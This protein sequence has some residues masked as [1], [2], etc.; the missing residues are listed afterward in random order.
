[1]ES[2]MNAPA[3]VPSEAVLREMCE[4]VLS[5]LETRRMP[6]STL[7]LNS[8]K[9]ARALLARLNASA[10]ADARPQDQI[11][12]AERLTAAQYSVDKTKLVGGPQAAVMPT[13]QQMIDAIDFD[14]MDTAEE[15][16][17]AIL[18][19]FQTRAGG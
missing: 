12:Y 13:R 18:E 8:K 16:V 17:D 10:H 9:I 7:L 19:L 2:P 4:L 1:M 5:P 15:V 14:G 11:D 3:D 6:H